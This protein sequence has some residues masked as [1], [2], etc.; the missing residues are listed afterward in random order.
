M[1]PEIIIF[2]FPFLGCRGYA[3][4]DRQEKKIQ[5][6][7]TLRPARQA[8]VAKEKKIINHLESSGCSCK[9]SCS[10]K[11]AGKIFSKVPRYLKIIYL[12]DFSLLFLF[13]SLFS[14]KEPSEIIEY[15]S[16]TMIEIYSYHFLWS[17]KYIFQFIQREREII[18]CLFYFA[19]LREFFL[20]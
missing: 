2:D 10:S 9:H 15:L 3:N 14:L 16:K 11:A 7:K 19:D 17:R 1:E 5:K 20:Y 6:K 8:S 4:T 18:P 13:Q 12:H